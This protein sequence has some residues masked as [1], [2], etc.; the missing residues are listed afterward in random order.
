MP[1]GNQ[2]P[3]VSDFFAVNSCNVFL[4]LYYI[5]SIYRYLIF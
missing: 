3:I 4:V 2:D 1:F 5:L